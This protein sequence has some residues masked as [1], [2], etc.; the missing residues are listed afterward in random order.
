MELL[1]GSL[2]TPSI[3]FMNLAAVYL[4]INGMMLSISANLASYLVVSSIN[5]VKIDSKIGKYFAFSK[6]DMNLLVTSNAISNIL[7]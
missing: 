4:V 1:A 6:S 3:V 5:C 7:L 2:S